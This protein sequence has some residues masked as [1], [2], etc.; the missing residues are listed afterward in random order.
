MLLKI[1]LISAADTTSRM[2][3]NDNEVV[4]V[5]RRYGKNYVKLLHV[6]REGPVHHIKEIEVNTAIQLNNVKDFMHGMLWFI[7]C[8]KVVLVT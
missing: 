2:P 8:K 4:F 1:W 3:L 7:H 5:D 6:K